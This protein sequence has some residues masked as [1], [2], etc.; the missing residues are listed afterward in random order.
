MKN[1][2]FLSFYILKIFDRYTKVII[3]GLGLLLLAIIIM[4]SG[5]V[6]LSNSIS[7]GMVGTFTQEDLPKQ[8]TSLIS[9][10]LISLDSSGLP[11]PNLVTGWD[12][13]SD[14]TMYTFKLKP[15]LFWSDGARVKSSDISLSIEGASVSFPDDQTIQVKL[16]DSFTP[17][18][19][20][21]TAPILRNNSTVGLGPYKVNSVETTQV[22]V[23]KL[24]LSSVKDD[25]PNI[26]IRFYPNEK[27]ALEALKLGEVQSLIGVSQTDEYLNSSPYEVISRSN[28]SR[29]VTIFYNTSDSVLS[30]K[31][32]RLALSFGAPSIQGEEEARTSLSPKSWAFNPNVKNYLDNPDQAKSYLDKVNNGKDST[33]VLTATAPLQTVGER[34][35]ASWNKM[36]IK[37][38]LKV[39]SG[40]PQ[41]FQALLISQDIPLDPDQYSLWHSTQS[42]TNVSKY[43]SKRVDKDLEDGRRTTKLDVRKSQYEDFQKVLL[44]DSPAAFLYFP[45][46][47]VIALKK[48]DSGLKK[49]LPLQLSSFGF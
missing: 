1:I 36:G 24:H 45:R 16:N 40:I 22:F 35:V 47:S 41:K 14:A 21:L 27:T 23:T 32:F 7:E 48:I 8:V 19:S 33:I 20:L 28:Y 10:P 26:T 2:R 4:L 15:N 30:D 3:P 31:N 6:K 43:S 9:A 49:V 11:K 39:E 12:V 38:S 13:N 34:V 18:P 17:L 29:L 44:D 5:R 37:S 46:Y 42:A 25:L